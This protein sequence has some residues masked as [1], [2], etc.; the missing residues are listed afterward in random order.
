M[1]V[2]N[3]CCQQPCRCSAELGEVVIAA[4]WEFNLNGHFSPIK[5]VGEHL[6]TSPSPNTD[7]CSNEHTPNA[8]IWGSSLAEHMLHWQCVLSDPRAGKPK[9]L[10]LIMLPI[11]KAWLIQLGECVHCAC[12]LVHL[13][14]KAFRS[15]DSLT[16]TSHKYL[17]RIVAH[18]VIIF[19]GSWGLIGKWGQSNEAARLS[20]YLLYTP[21]AHSFLFL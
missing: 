12:V 6:W 3:T 8:L 4:P 13:S 21:P 16:V 11:S 19:I 5:W 18:F 20:G 14:F 1:T 17:G 9:N 7:H 10:V 2:S 15:C